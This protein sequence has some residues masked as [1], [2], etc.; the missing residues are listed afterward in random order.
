MY[1]TQNP[2]CVMSQ[3]RRRGSGNWHIQWQ[4]DPMV[5]QARREGRRSRAAYKLEELARRDKFLRPGVRVLDLGAAPGGWSQVASERVGPSGRVVAVDRLPMK[6]IAGVIVIQ[7]DITQRDVRQRVLEALD[8]PAGIVL[9][10]MAP[11]ITGIHEAD[12][13]RHLQLLDVAMSV[14]EQ[15]LARDGHLLMKLFEGPDLKEWLSGVVEPK[16][17]SIRRIKPNASRSASREYYL[18][19]KYFLTGC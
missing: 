15:A 18:L 6:P 2:G 19:A 5:R 9:S 10:D 7:G 16:F 17:R 8:G 4:R 1:D 13:A 12:Q 14:A 11:N 3:R